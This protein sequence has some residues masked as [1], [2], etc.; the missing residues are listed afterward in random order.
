MKTEKTM[1]NKGSVIKAM[2]FPPDN[3]NVANN[4]TRAECAVDKIINITGT[5]ITNPIKHATELI[6]ATIICI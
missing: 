3:V 2:I 6:F 4:P 5:A 1:I